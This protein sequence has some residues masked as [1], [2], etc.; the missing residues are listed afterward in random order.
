MGR[1]WP[2][3]REA[4]AT[5]HQRP[6]GSSKRSAWPTVWMRAVLDAAVRMG[7]EGQGV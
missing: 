1:P 5:A 2:T 4:R 3:T 7:L 6:V